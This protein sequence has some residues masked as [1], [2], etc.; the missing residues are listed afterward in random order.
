MHKISFCYISLCTVSALAATCFLCA[1]L[2]GS[3]CSI[4]SCNYDINISGCPGN[5]RCSM[6]PCV[7]YPLSWGGKY[8]ILFP[9]RKSLLWQICQY[10]TA[11]HTNVFLVSPMK[12]ID[13]KCNIMGPFKPWSII[14]VVKSCV[15]FTARW[16]WRGLYL[17]SFLS[18]HVLA[19]SSI[20]KINGL[21]FP[22]LSDRRFKTMAS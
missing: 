20:L 6:F 9:C 2:G 8:C 16:I 7:I 4:T 14:C 12:Y 21:I 19:C 22:I 11:T 10:V 15:V 3:I 13:I 1:I 17:I 18:V 5:V